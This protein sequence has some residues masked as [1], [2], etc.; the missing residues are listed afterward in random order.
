MLKLG[1]RPPRMDPRTLLMASYADDSKLPPSP[2][3]LDRSYLIKSWGMMLNDRIGDCTCASVAH[4]VM[5]M[6]A[7][8]GKEFSTT[9]DDVLRMYE[10][11]GGYH[12]GQPDTDTGADLLTVMNYWRHEGLDGHTIGAYAKATGKAHLQLGIW[13]FGAISAGFALPLS[14]HDQDIWAVTDKSLRGDA[15]QGSWGGHAVPLIGYN[16]MGPVCITWGDV[17]QMTWDFWNAYGDEAYVPLSPDWVDGDKE[18]PSGFDIEQLTE[19][20]RALE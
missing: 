19:D 8:N 9:D 1:K 2:S 6:A 12:P 13:L 3:V 20:L 16:Q 7:A 14:C 10:A 4:A 5:L 15:A 18:A 11:V 17:K